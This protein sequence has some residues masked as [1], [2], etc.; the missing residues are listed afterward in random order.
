MSPYLPGEPRRYCCICERYVRQRTVR[1][2]ATFPRISLRWHVSNIRRR[3][4]NHKRHHKLSRDTVFGRART[5]KDSLNGFELSRTVMLRLRLGKA[6]PRAATSHMRST[7]TDRR[8]GWSDC[9]HFPCHGSTV[10]SE[11]F[12]ALH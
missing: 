3:S 1:G 5:S 12:R 2:I 11:Q 4:A 6:R 8:I 10:E 7:G 9:K